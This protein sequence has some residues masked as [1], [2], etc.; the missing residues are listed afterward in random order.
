VIY[1][2]NGKIENNGECHSFCLI[3][4]GMMKNFENFYPEKEYKT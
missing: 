1:K 3:I 2:L 4:N